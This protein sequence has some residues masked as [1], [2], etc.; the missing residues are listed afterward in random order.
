MG[1][2]IHPTALLAVS[3][4]L[5]ALAGP[6]GW[7]A[8]LWF[9]VLASAVTVVA[10]RL[11]AALP[12]RG[13]GVAISLIAVA[14]PFGRASPPQLPPEALRE[15]EAHRIEG[16]VVHLTHTEDRARFVLDRVRL[17][18]ADFSGRVRLTVAL[19]QPTPLPGLRIRTTARLRPVR[20]LRNPGY[21][22][23][24]TLLL[25]RGILATGS[26]ARGSPIIV[27]SGEP[28]VMGR[29]RYR[30]RRWVHG[31]GPSG[32][33]LQAV[34]LGDGAAVPDTQRSAW[35]DAGLAHLLAISGLHV[36]LIAW[37]VFR[38]AAWALGFWSRL[39]LRFG[40]LR[41]AAGIAIAAAWAYVLVAGSPT[42]ATRAGF[43]VS[44]FL[45]GIL[46]DRGP[47]PQTAL[48]VAAL[49]ILVA[50]PDA[51]FDVSFQLSFAAVF[52]LAAGMG[53]L[54]ERLDR[55]LPRPLARNGGLSRARSWLI[56]SFAA[57]LLCTV[58]TLPFVVWHFQSVPWAGLLA[59][60]VAIPLM[61]WGVVVPA[62]ASLLCVATGLEWVADLL[63]V[64]ANGGVYL[65]DHLAR[66]TASRAP[67]MAIPGANLAV[68]IGS[69]I[70][71]ALLLRAIC[72]WPRNSRFLLAGLV[73]SLGL[74]L[75]PVPAPVHG[76]LRI[77]FLAVGHGDAVLV[78][79]PD[80]RTMLV[81]GGGDPLGHFDVGQRVLI[82][83][84]SALGVERIDVLVLSHPHPDHYRGLVAVARHFPVGEFWTTDQPVR[85]PEYH[86]LRAIL[87]HR[88]VP[89]RDRDFPADLGARV[90]L[91]LLHP[92]PPDG[93]WFS[94]LGANDNSLVM[95]IR[96][97]EM[98]LL[99][100]GDVEGPAE[101]LLLRSGLD[102]RATVLKV[103]H[104]GSKTSS[105][106][107]F[108]AAVQPRLAVSQ[109][110]DFGRFAFPHD[111][112]Q[113][114][115]RGANIPLW[116][117]GRHGALQVKTDGTQMSY[118]TW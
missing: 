47:D 106:A 61:A 7:Q 59:N 115:Y 105:S 77:T 40:T 103:P 99:L 4:V 56:D 36:G 30:Y 22:D 78:Q 113:Q 24:G 89:T 34:V 23:P 86:R 112:V 73:T 93:T 80:G 10:S 97:G 65:A 48:G 116:I 53:P 84:L 92:R 51:L 46:L 28:S 13:L 94:R 100:T 21:R 43:M 117:T 19:S 91:E 98:S 81:D 15:L 52:C 95:R 11:G 25:T 63:A 71:A 20:P 85:D 70:L 72:V 32:A 33:V 101:Q 29:L 75:W 74:L 64:W 31:T 35:R 26:V 82:P 17:N 107:A 76:Q 37:L 16:D 108:L 79:L 58:G 41:L 44:A 96:Y 9:A 57:S 83:A 45:L 6:R 104:H 55:L 68:L 110:A 114:R 54:R 90:R 67:P 111:V 118:S 27:V 42:S 2:S 60:I 88:G 12:V 5:V 18:G 109:S 62:L 50:S 66:A 69:V 14:L 3:L 87:A 8:A 49:G 1:Y 38:L 102:L 39:A